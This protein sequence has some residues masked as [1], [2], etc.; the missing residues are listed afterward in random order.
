ML[1]N[2]NTDQNETPYPDAEDWQIA[3][4]PF[5]GHPYAA[6]QLGF[7]LTELKQLIRHGLKTCEASEAIDRAI[8]CLYEHSDFRS[9]SRELFLIAIQ[10]KLTPTTEDLLRQLGIK[11]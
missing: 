7:H 8:D 1:N 9:V 6:L 5:A 2:P 3:F 10:G 11:V 4:E